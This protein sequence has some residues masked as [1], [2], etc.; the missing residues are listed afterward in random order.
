M[1]T[2]FTA[3]IRCRGRS[4]IE[5]TSGSGTTSFIEYL[6]CSKSIFGRLAFLRQMPVAIEIRSGKAIFLSTVFVNVSAIFSRKGVRTSYFV[7][8]KSADPLQDHPRQEG[9]RTKRTLGH[10]PYREKAFF[11]KKPQVHVRAMCYSSMRRCV[12]TRPRF[13]VDYLNTQ[14]I[15]QSPT[16]CKPHV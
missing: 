15:I 4:P 9:S 2:L 11:V 10:S 8:R 5:K 1:D 16:A 14:Q 12:A 3:R 7:Q 13:Q 6:H